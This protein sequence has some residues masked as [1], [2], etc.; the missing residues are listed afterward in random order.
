VA[1][2]AIVRLR[3]GRDAIDETAVDNT[4]PPRADAA[5]D[6]GQGGIMLADDGDILL[7]NDDGIRLRIGVK[8]RRKRWMWT[9]MPPR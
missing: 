9:V 7:A 1:Y 8:R 2:N 4:S 6:G 3:I 5:N